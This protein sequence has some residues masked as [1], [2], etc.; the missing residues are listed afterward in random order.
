MPNLYLA[1]GACFFLVIV[2]INAALLLRAPGRD[3]QIKQRLAAMKGMGQGKAAGPVTSTRFG[4]LQ[5]I[6]LA[7]VE[8]PLIGAKEQAKIVLQLAEAGIYGRD[9]LRIFVA[10]KAAL[11]IGLTIFVWL[12]LGATGMAPH[13]FIWR[14]LAIIGPALLGWRLP[15]MIVGRMAKRRR[16]RLAEGVPDAL[17]LLVICVEAGLGL[18]QSLDRVSRDIAIANPVIATALGNAVAEMRVLPQMRDALDNL[19]R[20]TGLPAIKSVV[21]TLIQGIQY[22]TPLSQSLR[23]LSAEMRAKNLIALEERAARLPVLLM[24]PVILFIL[25]SLF[26]VIGGPVAIQVI[27]VLGS[28]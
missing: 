8:S 3:R 5:K 16:R 21:T 4:T 23:I 6:G 18:E 12:V 28:K 22:G 25:P 10:V 19:A 9:A 26:L 17:D 1:I 15:D 2:I 27:H 11:G 14:T 7:L 20:N 24:I 13:S